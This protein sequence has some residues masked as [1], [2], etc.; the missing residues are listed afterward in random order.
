MSSM[1][2]GEYNHSLDAK[3]RVIIPSK[4]REELGEKFMITK[5]M[6]GC[7]YVLPEHSFRKLTDELSTLPLSVK[8]SR[9]LV[10]YFSGGAVDGELDKQGR[11]LIPTSL[12]EYAGFEKD[13]VLVGVLDKIEVWSKDK[14]ENASNDVN[15]DVIE[16]RLSQLGLSI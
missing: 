13:V 5:G 12:R 10:R 16:E 14:W 11:V 15:M 9:A 6:D 3:G 2:V 8:D 1:F 4:Y 7:L